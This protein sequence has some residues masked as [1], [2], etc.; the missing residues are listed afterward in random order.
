MFI[1]K[2]YTRVSERSPLADKQSW[3]FKWRFTVPEKDDH[4]T[5]LVDSSIVYQCK[6]HE[7][8]L[9]PNLTNIL[10]L[11]YDIILPVPVLV[12][13]PKTGKPSLKTSS[14]RPNFLDSQCCV[15]MKR[16]SCSDCYHVLTMSW[17]R[18]ASDRPRSVKKWKSCNS[19]PGGFRLGDW[20]S[21]RNL[22]WNSRKNSGYYFEFKI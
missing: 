1:L 17:N 16:G 7:L 9:F 18:A 22:N 20:S 12:H 4:Q 8:Q 10:T 15:E 21:A 6:Q 14:H 19:W 11:L 2:E 5:S 3:I 13:L